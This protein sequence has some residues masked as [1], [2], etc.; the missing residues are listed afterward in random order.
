MKHVTQMCKKLLYCSVIGGIYGIKTRKPVADP[1]V[2]GG[3]GG[4][5]NCIEIGKN[6]GPSCGSTTGN[7]N[8]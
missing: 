5:R 4:V 7:A 6:P 1:S 8:L 2:G 3:G